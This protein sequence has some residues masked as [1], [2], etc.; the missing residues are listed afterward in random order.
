MAD[1]VVCFKFYRN[2]L[3]GFRTAMGQKMGFPL[4]L[5]VALTTGQQYRTT[6]A[7]DKINRSNMINILVGYNFR[8]QCTLML[9]YR[10]VLNF[11]LL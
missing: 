8:T 11:F 10:R 5:T 2:R 3:R 6:T 7:C 4:T 9:N 1:L